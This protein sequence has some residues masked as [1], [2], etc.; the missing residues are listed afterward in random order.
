MLQDIRTQL[1]E[2]F[3]GMVESAVASIPRLLVAVVLILLALM[4]AKIVERFLRAIMVRV[5][6]DAL[7]RRSGVDNWLTRIGVRRS[8]DEVVPRVIYFTLLFLFAREAAE[9][10]GLSAVAEAIGAVIGYLPNLI[11]AFLI[12]LIGSA[13]AQVGGR[14]VEEAARGAG[15]EFAPLLGRL[16]TGIL[17]FVLVVMALGELEIETLLVRDFAL[18]L[19]A[20]AVFGSAISFGMGSRDI[21]RNILAGFYIRKVLR[22]GDQV[23]IGSHKGRLEA[24][25]P[26]LT[27]LKKKDRTVI[28][29]NGT[30]LDSEV[31]R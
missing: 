26:A 25:S 2:I 30:F 13:I 17:L 14:A 6:F 31:S 1:Q 3:G 5:R 4:A 16:L 28:L 11:S 19:L 8:L 22:V 10:L 27:L 23:E 21:T 12:L 29:S 9:S 15:V 7:V 20:G 18:V 24:F